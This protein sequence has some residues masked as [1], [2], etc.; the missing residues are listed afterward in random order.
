MESENNFPTLQT[1]LLKLR[2]ILYTTQKDIKAKIKLI[3][4]RDFG[5]PMVCTVDALSEEVPG[6]IPG[7]TN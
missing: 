4:F 5:S 1:N 7:R 6:L 2:L 3:S